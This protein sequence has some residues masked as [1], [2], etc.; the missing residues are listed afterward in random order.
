LLP[1]ASEAAFNSYDKRHDSFCF[2][3]TRVDVLKEISEWANGNGEKCIFWLNGMAGTGKST[4]ARTVAHNYSKQNRLAASFFFSRGGGDVSHAGKFITTIARQLVNVSPALC[5]HICE[6]IAEQKEIASQTPRHQWN[7]LILRP[8]SKLNSTSLQSSILLV[9]DALDECEKDDDIKS[10]LEL[11]PEAKRLRIFITSRPDTPIR[12]GFRAM[13]GI[14]HHDLVLHGV[15]RPIV[16]HDISVFFRVHFREI[17]NSSEYLPA[18]WPGEQTITRLVQSAGGLF[19]WAATACRFVSAGKKFAASRLS[20]ILQGGASAAPEK[21]LN[22]IYMSILTNSVSDE[23]NDQEKKE[24]YKMLKTALG[25]IVIL[26]SSLSA[27]SL[28]R[29]LQIP[30]E[31]VQRMLEDLH[32]ILDIP[33]EQSCSIRLHHPSFRDFLL[34]EERCSDQH[35]WVDEKKAHAALA[36]ACIRLMSD[37]LGRDICGLNLP[38]VL[39]EEAQG[40]RIDQHLPSEL[41]YACRYWVQHLQRGKTQLLDDGQMHMFLRGHLLHWLEAL[42][43]MRKT[44]EGVLA[45]IS[46]ESLVAVSESKCT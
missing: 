10:L 26:F 18:D 24:L 12:H 40:D 13:P 46:L 22:M 2:D 30:K 37:K 35:F 43:L 6:A 7:Q 27:V 38:G 23:Y 31:D 19:I 1:T 25:T 3:E 16:D 39:A 14:L 45:I 29:L 33:K 8:L 42:S 5:R 41:Q 15:S 9:I 44:S 11:L 28:A 17:R 20:L 32:A 4:I 34:D 36:D 21:K